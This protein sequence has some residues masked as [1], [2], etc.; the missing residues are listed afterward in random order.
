MPSTTVHFK[1][2]LLAAIDQAA[3]RRGI[4]RNRFVMEACEKAVD[5]EH[6][7]WPDGFLEP[8]LNTEERT[9]V[10]EATA[11]LESA[12]AAARRN[13]GTTLL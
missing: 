13:R 10:A 12:V 11:E 5:E 2:E 7:H 6:G 8:S 9:L 1:D 4:S 3:S